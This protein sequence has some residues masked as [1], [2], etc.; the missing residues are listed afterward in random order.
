MKRHECIHCG[1]T[2]TRPGIG[3]TVLPC[4][5]CM[6]TGS[7]GETDDLCKHEI[8][9]LD[10]PDCLKARYLAYSAYLGNLAKGFYYAIPALSIE[11]SEL[12]EK[13]K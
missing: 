8:R 2:G 12:L 6:Q 4:T 10:C 11:I 9:V 3:A 1:G 7:I 13:P 5:T